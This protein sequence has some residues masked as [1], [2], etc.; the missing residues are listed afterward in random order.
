MLPGRQE[1]ARHASFKGRHLVMFDE[2]DRRSTCSE[3]AKGVSAIAGK[4]G[5]AGRLWPAKSS[6]H[7]TR[8]PPL[9]EPGRQE[10]PPVPRQLQETNCVRNG[11]QFE[12]L[13]GAPARHATRCAK[14]TPGCPNAQLSRAPYVQR[15]PVEI[16]LACRHRCWF[17]DAGRGGEEPHGRRWR[18]PRR[19]L[20]REEPRA[21]VAVVK[22]LD[23]EGAKPGAMSGR[24]TGREFPVRARTFYRYINLGILDICNLELPKGEIQAEAGGER[25]TRPRSGIP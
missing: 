14:S 1:G 16:T 17:Y 4:I 8:T 6:E 24:P 15:V 3:T 23:E 21:M 11:L 5:A 13:D 2:Q 10:P 25:R 12:I 18:P 20:F 22:P 19:R 9:P 7:R